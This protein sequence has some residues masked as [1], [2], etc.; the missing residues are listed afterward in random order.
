MAPHG[1][2]VA[3]RTAAAKDSLKI[4]RRIRMLHPVRCPGHLPC[5]M[6]GSVS[7]AGTGRESGWETGPASE[8][9][10]SASGAMASGSAASASASA[11]SSSRFDC[12]FEVGRPSLRN[13][14]PVR[15]ILLFPES[16][17]LRASSYFARAVSSASPI[18]SSELSKAASC[19][20]SAVPYS[21]CATA[22]CGATGH[23]PA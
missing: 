7:A 10:P 22:R 13:R 17:R 12:R 14:S 2:G 11:S 16:R 19:S 8:T 5:P 9:N 4:L 23:R 6:S 15:T 21:D 20:Y 1:R 3:R 18:P